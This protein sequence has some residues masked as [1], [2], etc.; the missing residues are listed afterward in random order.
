MTDASCV[1]QSEFTGANAWRRDSLAVDDGF[2]V[3]DQACLDELDGAVLHLRANPLPVEMITPDLFELPACR[4]LMK[5]VS[6]ELRDGVGFAIVDRLNLGQFARQEAVMVYWLLASMI[7]RPVAQKWNGQMIY[8]VYDSGRK[9]GHGVRPDITNVE[10]NF[11]TD[12]SYN[13]SPP[14]I[15][16]LLCL[17]TAKQGGISRIISF[18]SAHNE[19]LRRYGEYLPRLYRPYYFDRQREHAP[20]DVK[21]TFH[22]L[23]ANESGALVARLSHFQVVNGYVLAG[24]EF[25]A[26][27]AA[28]LDA[29]EGILNEPT[30]WKDFIFEPGQIQ[31]LDNRRCGHKRTAFV[32]HHAPKRKRRLV[33]LWLRNSGRPFYNG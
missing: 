1:I 13:H 11:H 26:H 6:A 10:Q 9:P 24:E 16:G 33:R 25:D 32:D 22:P 28:A 27:G 23:F 12:N 19:M 8:D 30:M 17:Q 3:L 15:I 7:A 18:P 4:A 14:H 5:A 21:T 29:L 20:G 2:F 31:F